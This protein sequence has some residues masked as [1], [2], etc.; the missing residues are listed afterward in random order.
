MRYEGTHGWSKLSVYEDCALQFALTYIE[1][2]PQ[3]SNPAFTKGERVHTAL[4]RFLKGAAILPKE[5]LPMSADLRVLKKAKA[6]GEK[7]ITLDHDWNYRG[8]AYAEG[9]Y[10]RGGIDALKID[11]DKSADVI[12]F[13][14]GRSKAKPDQPRFYALLTFI[15]MPEIQLIRPGLWYVEQNLKEPVKPI[16][17]D[18]LEPMKIEFR[19]RIERIEKERNWRPSMGPQCNWCQY[20]KSKGGPCRF[21]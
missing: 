17:R 11:K 4:D 2:R 12:D 13:K 8:S 3:R 7:K 15:A 10:I 21:G 1:K 20:A 9:D 16:S 6:Q 19:Q 18:M 5:A 14:T